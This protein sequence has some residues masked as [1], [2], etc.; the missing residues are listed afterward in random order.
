MTF[1]YGLVD[2][3]LQK[4]KTSEKTR[5]HS[6]VASLS[7]NVHETGADVASVGFHGKKKK[8]PLRIAIMLPVFH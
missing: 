4:A 2:I 3:Q 6:Q 8:Q 7:R 5:P 1:A